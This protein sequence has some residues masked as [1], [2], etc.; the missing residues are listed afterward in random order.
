MTAEDRE[1]LD[2]WLGPAYSPYNQGISGALR[3]SCFSVAF[4]LLVRCL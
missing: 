4:C 1:K 3:S 2:A